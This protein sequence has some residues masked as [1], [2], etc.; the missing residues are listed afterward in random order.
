MKRPTNG[1]WSIAMSNNWKKETKLIIKD[2]DDKINLLFD[3]IK[4][5]KIR[6]RWKSYRNWWKVRLKHKQH[7]NW[8]DLIVV[9][10]SWSRA[11]QPAGHLSGKFASF[12]CC[13]SHQKTFQTLL[14]MTHDPQSSCVVNMMPRGLMEHVRDLGQCSFSH[15][16]WRK[17]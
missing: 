7:V 11:Y 13:G 4:T 14:V 8:T 16:N 9:M 12:T 6:R 17:K 2:H 3:Y 5:T 10:W 15:P 1:F